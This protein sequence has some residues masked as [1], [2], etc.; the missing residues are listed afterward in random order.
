MAAGPGTFP[1]SVWQRLHAAARRHGLEPLSFEKPH[2]QIGNDPALA[3]FG[4][5]P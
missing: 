4:E 3:F 2:L 1:E 5:R